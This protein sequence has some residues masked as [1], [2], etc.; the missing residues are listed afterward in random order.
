MGQNLQ[1][2]GQA[3]SIPGSAAPGSLDPGPRQSSHCRDSLL[4]SQSLIYGSNFHTFLCWKAQVDL[5]GLAIAKKP[6]DGKPG[7]SLAECLHGPPALLPTCALIPPHR[8]RGRE[9]PGSKLHCFRPSHLHIE[10]NVHS[11][12]NTWASPKQNPKGNRKEK[13][14][15]GPA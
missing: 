9:G 12:P 11:L 10:L 8:G 1:S 7:F 5:D 13:G 4:P 2:A 3:E 6:D 14:W 15:G